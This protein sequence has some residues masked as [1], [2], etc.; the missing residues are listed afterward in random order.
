MR[1]F[2]CSVEYISTIP[3]DWSSLKCCYLKTV[4]TFR[5]CLYI[6]YIFFEY[7]SLNLEKTISHYNR[8]LLQ[9]QYYGISLDEKYIIN[10]FD[11]EM[12]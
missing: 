6:K 12:F 5:A 1:Q 3:K 7:I 4:S 9:F 2:S 11:K 8:L 10:C